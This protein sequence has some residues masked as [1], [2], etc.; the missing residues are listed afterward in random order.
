M[1]QDGIWICDLGSANG[2]FISGERQR[3]NEWIKYSGG[4]LVLGDPESG[5]E[6]RIDSDAHSRSGRT[7]EIEVSKEADRLSA[8]VES[9]KS[10]VKRLEAERLQSEEKQAVMLKRL[11]KLI[12][13]E[14]ALFKSIDDLKARSEELMTECEAIERTLKDWEEKKAQAEVDLAQ[15]ER[16][17]DGV[18]EANRL[19]ELRLFEKRDDLKALAQAY[20]LEINRLEAERKLKVAQIENE[21]E[22]LRARRGS[23]ERH[24]ESLS[25]EIRFSEERIPKLKAEWETIYQILS[26]SRTELK[27]VR[28]ELPVRKA[29]LADTE[30]KITQLREEQERAHGKAANILQQADKDARLLL[31]TAEQQA[32]DRRTE[33]DRELD[34]LRENQ[35]VEAASSILR[36]Q[37]DLQQKR[38]EFE[39]ERVAALDKLKSTLDASEKANIEV[40]RIAREKGLEEIRIAIA[41]EEQRS[42]EALTEQRVLFSKRAIAQ[43]ITQIE[44]SGAKVE[45]AWVSRLEGALLEA[46]E[47]YGKSEG[48]QLET[49]ERSRQRFRMKAA[50]WSAVG[51]AALLALIS[52]PQFL[53]MKYEDL[54]RENAAEN[55]RFIKDLREQRARMLA[56]Q[57]EHKADFQSEYVMNILY[58]PGYLALKQDESWQK[59]WT[60]ALSRFF[61]EELLLDDQKVVNFLPV[62]TA[63]IRSLADVNRVLNKAN[64]EVN[65]AKMKGIEQAKLPELWLAAGGRENWLK[66]R[67]FEAAF[68]RA[69]ISETG[70]P[71]RAVERVPAGK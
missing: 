36:L 42:R 67:K 28:D 8:K 47:A 57:L 30:Q 33:C 62:E 19:E 54:K 65:F 9:L 16:S 56:L 17:L 22:E 10:E 37:L 69:R 3:A 18:R 68:Y 5:P 13:R 48:Y 52:G 1:D 64:F 27:D 24:L 53:S 14:V 34:I 32:R 46:I 35:R 44:R 26:A 6:L 7:V 66:I 40:L 21:F 61:F 51:V 49:V 23:V 41:K 55:D 43:A 71:V 38:D 4:R 12:F 70:E 29:E 58:N 11:D 39:Q 59:E 50:T 15:H 60:G 2:T 31:E 45:A 25:A 63:M 20:E